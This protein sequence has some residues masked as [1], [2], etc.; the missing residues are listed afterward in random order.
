MSNIINLLTDL[1]RFLIIIAYING[2]RTST[3]EMALFCTG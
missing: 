2:K 1:L 3:V